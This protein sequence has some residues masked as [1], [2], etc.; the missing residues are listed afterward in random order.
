MSNAKTKTA[1]KTVP[2]LQLPPEFELMCKSLATGANAFDAA[3]LKLDVLIPEA[4]IQAGLANLIAKPTAKSLMRLCLVAGGLSGDKAD[5]WIVAHRTTIARLFPQARAVLID[6]GVT[7]FKSPPTKTATPATKGKADK[8]P[9]RASSEPTGS[10]LAS[11]VGYALSAASEAALSAAWADLPA[12]TK[13][14]VL[15]AFGV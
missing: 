9:A 11:D 8:T 3:A 12:S 4:L 2:A 15:K 7:G 6:A 14:K 5:A 10:P 1:T 13:A